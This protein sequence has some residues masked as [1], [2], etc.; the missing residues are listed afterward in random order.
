MDNIQYLIDY[1]ARTKY[2]DS[3]APRT[4]IAKEL[5]KE[6]IALGIPKEDHILAVMVRLGVKK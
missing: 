2:K 3:I 5:E 1:L 6:L 4:A